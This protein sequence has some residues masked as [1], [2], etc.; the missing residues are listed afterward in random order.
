M[1]RLAALCL[2]VVA[3]CGDNSHNDV[4]AAPP[5]PDAPIAGGGDPLDGGT[6]V[7]FAEPEGT[8]FLIE[9]YDST[10][11]GRD[12]APIVA[13]GHC[14][15]RPPLTVLDTTVVDRDLGPAVTAFDGTHTVTADVADT[16]TFGLADFLLP[17]VERS[18]TVFFYGAGGEPVFDSTWML[19]TDAGP[20]ATVAV[21]QQVFQDAIGDPHTAGEPWTIAYSGGANAD[22]I[23]IYVA[24]ANGTA[25]CYAVP[26]TTSFTIPAAVLDAI[27][28]DNGSAGVNVFAYNR[29]VQTI[30][31]RHVVVAG[32]AQNLD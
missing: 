25:D 18:G 23:D 14:D 10:T 19:T 6:I 16:I 24:G 30:A 11:K 15:V 8:G 2:V 17:E 9:L 3:A 26:G 7:M 4:D 27:I 1:T 32:V 28:D 5:Q 31:G 13:D 22:Y 20:L 21:P 29:S 12:L